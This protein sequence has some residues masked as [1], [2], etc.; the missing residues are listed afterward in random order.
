LQQARGILAIV[1]VLMI[2]SGLAMWIAARNASRALLGRGE[3]AAQPSGDARGGA[4][5]LRAVHSGI[6]ALHGAAVPPQW[7]TPLLS[8]AGSGDAALV[9]AELSR[10]ASVQERNAEG[11][12]ALMLASQSGSIDAVVALL[13]AG[14]DASVVDDRGR[15]ARDF[16]LA[17]GDDA[18][19]AIAEILVQAGHP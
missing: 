15:S 6:D 16:A 3:L 13:N 4:E 18:G 10:G 9:V 8:A 1:A 17:R 12:T 19:R 14:A 2:G 7:P 11:A 5:A